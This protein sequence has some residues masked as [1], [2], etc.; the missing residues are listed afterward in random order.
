MQG[1]CVVL[2]MQEQNIGLFIHLWV[3]TSPTSLSIYCLMVIFFFWVCLLYVVTVLRYC[4]DWRVVVM[5]IKAVGSAVIKICVLL[6][7]KIN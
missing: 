6:Y 3:A 2:R 7:K 1:V 4:A 5:R